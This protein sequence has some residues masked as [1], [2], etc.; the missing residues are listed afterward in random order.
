MAME[1]QIFGSAL[2]KFIQSLE[3][4][5]VAKILR[6]IDLLERFGLHLGMPHAK[7]AKDH[8]LELRIRGHQEVRIFL[9]FS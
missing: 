7:K 2:E 4:L 5:T 1:I 9:H 8:L 3:K 6:T